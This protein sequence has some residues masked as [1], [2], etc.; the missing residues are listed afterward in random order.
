M[1]SKDK[2][3]LASSNPFLQSHSGIIRIWHWI[4]FLLISLILVTVILNSTLLNARANAVVV[5]ER[6]AG[7]SITVDDRQAFSIA[8]FFDDQLWNLHKY[9]GII[10]SVFILVRI[11]GEFTI[12]ADERIK[13]R[14]A[15]AILKSKSGITESALNKEYL[16]VR[17]SYSLFYVLILYM[18]LSGLLMSF[19]RDL[20][21][22]GN[23]IRPI[24]EIHGFCQWLM[25]AFV[26]FHIGGVILADLGKAKGVVSGMIHGNKQN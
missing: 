4:T 9:L 5:K 16:I 19:G 12:P 25:Y 1:E 3:G 18:V 6:L 14:M 15:S 26:L 20:G 23:V 24:R 13:H 2:S 7:Q 10:L 22:P 17:I 11:I 8:H 21:V